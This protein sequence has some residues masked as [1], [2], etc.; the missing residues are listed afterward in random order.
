MKT[1]KKFIIEIESEKDFGEK[2]LVKNCTSCKYGDKPLSTKCAKCLLTKNLSD[3][4]PVGST[5]MKKR[6]GNKGNI[7]FKEDDNEKN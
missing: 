3:Y 4:E 7:S 2:I 6:L 1:R 5:T